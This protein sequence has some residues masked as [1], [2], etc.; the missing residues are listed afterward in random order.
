MTKDPACR[1]KV[2][3]KTAVKSEY[4][5][6]VYYFCCPACKGILIKNRRSIS[7]GNRE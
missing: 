1:M 4:K 2:D 3:E 5:K 7:G 6:K